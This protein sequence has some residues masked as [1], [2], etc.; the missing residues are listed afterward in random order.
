M[1]EEINIDDIFQITK[2]IYISLLETNN[3]DIDRT[4]FEELVETEKIVKNDRNE[5]K[6]IVP[7]VFGTGA[8]RLNNLALG[9]KTVSK[10]EEKIIE[11]KIEKETK[12]STEVVKFGDLGIRK[13]NL[14]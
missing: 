11:N 8:R 5:R 10:L 14:E 12:K 7:V 9:I 3:L 6:K 1:D 13:I 2:E 4:E